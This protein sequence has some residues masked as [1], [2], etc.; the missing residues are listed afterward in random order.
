MVTGG[1]RVEAERD[2]PA[3]AA[4]RTSSCGCTRRTGSASRPAAYAVDVR[5][6]DVRVEVVGEVEDVVRDAELGRDAARRPRRRRRCSTRSRT[7]PPQSLS[8]TPVTSWPASRSSAAATDESTP[9]LIAH[10]HRSSAHAAPPAS[11]RAT[12]SGIDVERGVDVGVGRRVAEAEAGS[13]RARPR[14]DRPIAAS[15]CDGSVAPDEHDE[16]AAAYTP[17]RSSVTSSV[18]ASTPGKP[19]WQLP[20]TLRVEVAVDEQ[21]RHRAREPARRA[22][23]AAPR[24]ARPPRRAR[25]CVTRSAVGERD[26]AGDVDGAGPQPALLATALDL[27]HERAC[28]PRTTSAPTPFGPAE[29]VTGDRD[30]V[31]VRAVAA[32]TSSHGDGLHRVGVQHRVRAP[33]PGP[34]RPTS[35]SGW[36]V[37]DLVV[38]E[39]HRDDRGPLVERVG[40]RV[41][42]DDR[43]RGPT[44][45]VHDPEALASEPGRGAEDGLVLDR[46]GDDA[47]SV[48]AARARPG[49]RPSPPGCRASV[50]PAG[51]D[52]LTRRA[53]EHRGDVLAGLLERGLGRPGDA[54]AR[55]TG[56]P[57]GRQ[58][59]GSIA[60]TASGRIGV[61]AAWSRYAGTRSSV[62]GPGNRRRRESVGRNRCP[63]L[64]D[65]HDVT[66]QLLL[67]EGGRPTRHLDARTR[68]TGRKGIAEAR[69]RLAAVAAAAAERASLASSPAPAARGPRHPARRRERARV[70]HRWTPAG[71]GR[72]AGAEKGGGDMRIESSVT[73]ISWIPS[74]A[75]AGHD[76]AAVRDGRRPLR[77]A[78]ARR[79]S[80][81]S[82]SCRPPTGSGSPTS[83]GPGSTWSTAGSSTAGYSGGG[84]IGSTTLRLGAHDMTLAAT[85][86]ARPA[87][88]PGDRPDVGPLRPDRRRA[89]PARP[90]RGAV[91]HP[92]FLK[93]AAPT[94]WTTLELTINADGTSNGEAHRVQ[95]V[96]APLDLRRRAAS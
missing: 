30:Q 7:S 90:R 70:G 81:T 25:S 78:A 55:P 93:V 61:L 10:E 41:E 62:R 66:T 42:V 19:T 28:R 77:R 82:A 60:A 12:A 54:R 57:G 88:G 20:A 51:E 59:K 72:R 37:P 76:E 14:R 86:A 45:T 40:Q 44:P 50:P 85:A 33:G 73:S 48:A 13:T 17:A 26:R 65:T 91:N 2:A 64:G 5:R 47:V 83:C 96:P 4:G 46:G 27:G 38:H 94:A 69:R 11:S 92:P 36:I 21:P 43:R 35:A 6:D 52:D 3:R 24:C 15:T 79:R 23:R 39:H 9:P 34:A 53:A 56:C 80:T 71:R 95:H 58:R 68:K 87:P 29:L 1:D 22:G 31:A 49:P 74:E 67:L 16:P 84:R 32:A 89:R 63:T 8:V 18:S 75:I